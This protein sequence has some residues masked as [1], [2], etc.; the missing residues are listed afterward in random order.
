VPRSRLP[1]FDQSSEPLEQRI[2]NGLHKIGLALKHQTWVAASDEGLS[3]TQGQI[4]AALAMDGPLT[5]SELVGRL[6]VTLPTISDSARVLVEKGLVAKKPDQRHPR[7]SLLEL[8]SGGRKQATNVRAWPEFLAAAV[9]SLSGPEQEAFL[10]G[11]VKMIRALQEQGQIP[12]S[13]MCAT[14]VHFR[15]RVHEG[16]L[17]HHCAFV[18]APMADRHLRVDCKEHEEAPVTQREE[19]WARFMS[20]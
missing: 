1:L 2:A 14:C 7:A 8:T 20:R 12:V 19:A 4:L 5:G 11:L 10:A 16:S 17:P 3:P 13:R 18:D 9:G 6:G 15:P